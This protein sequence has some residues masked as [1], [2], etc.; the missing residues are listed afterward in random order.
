MATVKTWQAASFLVRTAKN[1]STAKLLG[2]SISAHTTHGEERETGPEQKVA[3]NRRE[4][5]LLVC[6]TVLSERFRFPEREEYI[7][8][9]ISRY[10]HGWDL[11]SNFRQ[12]ATIADTHKEVFKQ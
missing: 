2:I 6:K 4:Q 1:L 3:R 8:H 7:T 10:Y 5:R 11:L 12:S 9:N